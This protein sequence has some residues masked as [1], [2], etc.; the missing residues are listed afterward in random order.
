M[1]SGSILTWSLTVNMNKYGYIDVFP[2]RIHKIK[3]D[4]KLIPKITFGEDDYSKSF[5]FVDIL[6]NPIFSKLNE[7]VLREAS[8][9][10][11]KHP[12][13]GEWKIVG[14]WANKQEPEQ[15]GFKFHS[16]IN[17]FMSCVF[18]VEGEDMSLVV[19]EEAKEPRQSDS[20]TTCFY[21][22]IVRH[23]MHPEITLPVDVGDL[24]VFPSY[25]LHKSNT[26]YT[27]KNRIS[28]SYNLLPSKI[29]NED[30]PWSLNLDIK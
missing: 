2:T 15:D 3:L 7:T 14:A 30:L 23:N 4:T 12:S 11:P 8:M 21:D 6:H 17:S 22:I 9:V 16:H 1:E 19:K 24:L 26:N 13:I 28:I 20:T 5:D 25:Q 10:C 29:K 18:Y 27:N